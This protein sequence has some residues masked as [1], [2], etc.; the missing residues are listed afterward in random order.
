M[1]Q[2]KQISA[3]SNSARPGVFSLVV[4]IVMQQMAVHALALRMKF[5]CLEDNILKV[6]FYLRRGHPP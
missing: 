2:A 1:L 4:P 6:K 3:L 5:V